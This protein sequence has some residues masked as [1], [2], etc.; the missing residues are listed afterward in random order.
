MRLWTSLEEREGGTMPRRQ[1]A[2]S[3]FVAAGMTY[4]LPF[5][6]LCVVAA[7]V[8]L[9]MPG[10]AIAE[11]APVDAARCKQLIDYYDRY[12]AGRS[13]TSDGRRNMTRLSAGIDCDRGDYER[14]IAEMESLLI[15]KKFTVP[16]MP[17]TAP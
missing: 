13:A 2:S 8:C 17:R 3:E 1:Q 4:L 10:R 16:P 9:A 12:A 6:S 11:P 14:G 5:L 7:F 15:A